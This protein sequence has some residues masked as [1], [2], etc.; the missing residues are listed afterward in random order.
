MGSILIK[1]VQR[2]LKYPLILNELLK[3][4]RATSPTIVHQQTLLPDSGKFSYFRLQVAGN[5]FLI[6]LG[7][8]LKVPHI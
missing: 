6:L 1:P 7:K 5:I 3:E 8:E 4:C 2:I